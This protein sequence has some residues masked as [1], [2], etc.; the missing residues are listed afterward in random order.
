MSCSVC[1]SYGVDIYLI[2]VHH[3]RQFKNE[4]GTKYKSM[5]GSGHAIIGEG[6]VVNHEEKNRGLK[7]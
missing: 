6:E 4:M 1:S 5:V 2:F 7:W 3:L